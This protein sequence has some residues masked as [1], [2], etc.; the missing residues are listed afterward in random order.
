M[1]FSGQNIKGCENA[2]ISVFVRYGA[3]NRSERPVC[4]DVI[5]KSIYAGTRD[6]CERLL[7]I[8]KAQLLGTYPQ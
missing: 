4:D 1:I 8:I 7:P 3:P 2:I 6:E 5:L